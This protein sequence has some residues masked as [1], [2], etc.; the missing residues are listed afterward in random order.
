MN[1]LENHDL[2][3]VGH[4]QGLHLRPSNDI[5]QK[6]AQYPLDVEAQLHCLTTGAKA[7]LRSILEILML[8][9]GHG[10]QLRLITV[11][12]DPTTHQAIL[13]EVRMAAGHV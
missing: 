8:T 5:V 10:T 7:D 11:N 2:I 13:E 4:A 9:A 6:M 12:A 1:T 3:V